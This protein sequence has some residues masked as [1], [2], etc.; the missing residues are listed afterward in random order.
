MLLYTL[1]RLGGIL[2]TLLLLSLFTFTLS[3][4][5][6]GGPWA[7]GAEIPMSEQQVAAFKAKYGLDRPVWEQ[8]LVWLR[9]A[10]LLDFGRPF[11]E[12]ER[13]VTELIIRALP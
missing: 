1:K 5:V 2:M 13:T 9:N 6:P 10:L 11:T 4:V 3:R 8:Y 7:Q 12:P